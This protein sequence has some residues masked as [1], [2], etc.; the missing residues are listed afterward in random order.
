M[1][2]INVKIEQMY[3]NRKLIE[4]FKWNDMGRTTEQ[5]TVE[6]ERH[7][8]QQMN[9]YRHKFPEMRE[10]RWEYTD[11]GQGHYVMISDKPLSVFVG[12][13]TYIQ[14]ID[15][16]H[17]AI[18]LQ[19]WSMVENV[20]YS[21]KLMGNIQLESFADF[22]LPYAVYEFDWMFDDDDD[23][24]PDDDDDETV[25]YMANEVEKIHVYTDQIVMA[26]GNVE[27]IFTDSMVKEYLDQHWDDDETT[28]HW[29][30]NVG[31]EMTNA[32][33]RNLDRLLHP[34]GK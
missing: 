10:L 6:V 16:L 4:E 22:E 26:I 1:A 30:D 32:A 19:D 7:I 2:V 8:K 5:M 20:G 14:C 27:F 29:I 34:F 15:V 18:E 3:P 31:L 9:V 24:D 21:L 17:K 33:W 23:L 11:I 12:R 13:L 25:T 28:L